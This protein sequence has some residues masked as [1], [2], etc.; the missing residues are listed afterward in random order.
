MP[1]DN[2]ILDDL[3]RL[4]GGAV[5]TLAAVRH[6]IEARARAQLEAVLARMDMVTREEFEA[7]RTMAANARAAEEGLAQR[8]AALEE[9]LAALESRLVPPAATGE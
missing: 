6:E 4:A 2:R 1:T 3:A 8:V 9:R 5:D 7:A